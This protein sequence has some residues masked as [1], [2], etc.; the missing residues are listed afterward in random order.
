MLVRYVTGESPRD[1]ASGW[2]RLDRRPGAGVRVAGDHGRQDAHRVRSHRPSHRAG[3]RL[4][5]N[6]SAGSLRR[7]VVGV[8]V[9]A[10]L[11]AGVVWRAPDFD[12]VAVRLALA[13]RGRRRA[14]ARSCTCWPAWQWGR[15][16]YQSRWACAT[17]RAIRCNTPGSSCC[18]S[19]SPARPSWRRRWGGTLEKS[20]SDRINHQVATDIRVVRLPSFMITGTNDLRAGAIPGLVAAATAIRERADVGPFAVE[21][22]AVETRDFAH[23]SWYRDDYSETPLVE[24]MASVRQPPLRRE[25]GHTGRCHTAGHLGQ[26]GEPI[27]EPVDVG[28]RGQRGRLHQTRLHG[29]A[30]PARVAADDGRDQ[31]DSPAVPRRLR[32]DIRAGLRPGRNARHRGRRQPAHT[33]RGWRRDSVGELRRGA[34]LDSDRDG[35]AIVG[36]PRT[37]SQQTFRTATRPPGFSFGRENQRGIRGFY[38]SPT[39]GPLPVIV[40]DDLADSMGAVEGSPLFVQLGQHHASKSSWRASCGISRR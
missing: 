14:G 23:M 38:Q 5:G 3:H 29:R 25:A 10:V 11:V 35:A 13:R 34:P 32:P 24:V 19:S 37:H 20:R 8:A 26:S 36:P 4:P 31:Q 12:H 40:S 16:R 15:C 30:G 9:Q 18:S 17:W 28:G 33:D 22:L 7:T 1:S 6:G 2:P 21:L 27:H 39:A